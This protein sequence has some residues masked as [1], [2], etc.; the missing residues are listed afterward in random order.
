MIY[1]RKE[2]TSDGDKNR[3][4]MYLKDLKTYYVTVYTTSNLKMNPTKINLSV[5]QS[6][7][8]T[9][10]LRQNRKQISIIHDTSNK[11]TFQI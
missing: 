8:L 1:N 5:H 2:N 11:I 4:M 7:N 3:D 10:L 9:K 6:R